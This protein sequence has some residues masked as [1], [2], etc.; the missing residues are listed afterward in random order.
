MVSREEFCAVNLARIEPKAC[1]KS[2]KGVSA[3]SLIGLSPI[4]PIMELDKEDKR[5]VSAQTVDVD[6]AT[7]LASMNWEEFEHLVREL[8]DKEFAS[9]GGEVKVTRASSDGGVDAIAFD[10]DP[11]S[12]GKIVI[13]AKRYTKTVGIAAVR[14][15]YGTTMNEGAHKGILVTTSDYG[16]DAYKF[17]SDKPL[18]LMTGANLLHLLSKHGIKAKI[19][20]REARK[21]LGLRDK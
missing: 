5:F 18:M 11:I 3:A 1:F 14:D 20:L 13:Q 7:N 21:E 17:A 15:L 10:P 2:L 6:S 19:D 4:A 8:F 12:G 9:R 16:P